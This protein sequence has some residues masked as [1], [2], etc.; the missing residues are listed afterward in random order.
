MDVLKEESDKISTINSD[1]TKLFVDGN[2]KEVDVSVLANALNLEEI[3][4]DEHN[5]DFTSRSNIFE[6]IAMEARDF[7]RREAFRPV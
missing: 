4:V 5:Q 7:S 2:I 3:I 6:S 1:E